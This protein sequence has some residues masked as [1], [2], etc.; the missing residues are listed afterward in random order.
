MLIS[1]LPEDFTLDDL[2]HYREESMEFINP[3]ALSE[4]LNLV[5]QG[6]KRTLSNVAK[7]IANIKKPTFLR[8]SLNLEKAL[9]DVNYGNTR[10][11]DVPV[12]VGQKTNYR[13]LVMHLQDAALTIQNLEA[14]ILSPTITT[15][16]KLYS[17][18]EDLASN[19]NYPIFDSVKQ[20]HTRLM[21]IKRNIGDC[22]NPKSNH[23]HA[24]FGD[25]F[26]NNKEVIEV[27]D[28]IHALNKEMSKINTDSIMKR[29][30]DLSDVA[31][32]IY[33]VIKTST[34]HNPSSFMTGKLTELLFNIAEEVEFLG[35][36]LTFHVS[37]NN[38]YEDVVNRIES[39]FH[40]GK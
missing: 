1:L 36:L 3:N 2:K 34:K 9:K 18:S 14:D 22:F 39:Y 6:A 31:D 4:K 8:Y 24:S 25:V 16:N 20:H 5:I 15:M 27:R 38:T 26:G 30:K 37:I 21:E 19:Y 17:D 33:K 40:N 10:V 13:T 32:D 7:D 28:M 35:A 11:V 12:L 29:V 23:S